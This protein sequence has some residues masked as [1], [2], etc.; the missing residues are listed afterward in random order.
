MDEI[1]DLVPTN[2]IIAFGGDYNKPVEK[3][4]G[5]L[6]MARENISQVLGDRVKDGLMT[7]DEAIE[8]AKQWFY[9]NPKE[10]YQ[11]QI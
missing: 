6:V 5:H 8:I 9:E 3:I 1:L 11:L 2:K 10:L 7:E 4:Y